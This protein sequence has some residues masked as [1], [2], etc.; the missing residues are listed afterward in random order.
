MER[1][2]GDGTSGMVVFNTTLTSGEAKSYVATMAQLDAMLA[3]SS[4]LIPQVLDSPSPSSPMGIAYQK[5]LRDPYEQSGLLWMSSEDHLRTV[6]MILQNNLLPMFS[7]YSL[8]RPPAEADVRMAFLLDRDINETVRLGR[9]LSVRFESLREQH[10]VKPNLVHF[11]QRLA[12]IEKKA[13][14]N[15]IPTVRSNPK[16]GA[17][18]VIGFG[19]ALKSEVELFRTY[20]EGGELLYRLLSSHVHARPWGWLDSRKAAPTAEAG[21]SR[22]KAE[23]DIPLYVNVVVLTLKTHEKVLIRLLELAGRTQDEWEAA[24]RAALNRVRPRY[25]ALLGPAASVPR[26]LS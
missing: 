7:L 10:K 17:P 25:L 11:A 6:L 5:M 4:E 18:E 21:V 22:L 13:T 20:H 12:V 1:G 24:K 19:G 9:G 2:G 23:L 16:K 3:A 14:D 15:G 8:L 26:P